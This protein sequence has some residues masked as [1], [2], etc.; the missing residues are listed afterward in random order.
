MF[1]SL[2]LAV[3]TEGESV[4]GVECGSTLLLQPSSSHS[5]QFDSLL[6]GAMCI[7]LTAPYQITSVPSKTFNET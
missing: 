7:S 5:Q 1:L 4:L 2:L 3:L 6:N